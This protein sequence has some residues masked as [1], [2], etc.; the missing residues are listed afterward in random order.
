MRSV[1]LLS[2]IWSYRFEP[3]IGQYLPS[4]L[5]VYSNDV[6]LPSASMVSPVRLRPSAVPSYVIVA[7]LGGGPGL[8]FDLA[9]L[10]FQVPIMGLAAHRLTPKAIFQKPSRTSC[11]LFRAG[12][13]GSA[14]WPGINFITF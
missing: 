7:L 8:Y 14:P 12:D 5:A 4:Y 13:Q 11:F 2:A 1:T 10:S 6:A 3:V 9:T